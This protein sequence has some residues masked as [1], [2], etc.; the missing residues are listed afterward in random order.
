MVY[1]V[2]TLREAGQRVYRELSTLS[3][4]LFSKAKIIPKLSLLK[5]GED[6]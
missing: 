4:Q 3:L 1:K 6:T 2:L 5:G